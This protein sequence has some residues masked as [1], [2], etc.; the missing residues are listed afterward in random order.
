MTTTHSPAVAIFAAADAPVVVPFAPGLSVTDVPPGPAVAV[1]LR[2]PAPIVVDV[3]AA[4]DPPEPAG[5]AC[6]VRHG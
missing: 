3:D 2:P 4:P 1:P 6:V 5:L